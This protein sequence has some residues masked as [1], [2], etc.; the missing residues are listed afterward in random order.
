MMLGIWMDTNTDFLNIA[1]YNILTLS[2][3]DPK[4]EPYNDNKL[5]ILP[6]L[7]WKTEY[8]KFVL[9]IM[10]I[11]YDLRYRLY[12]YY[13]KENT[14][15]PIYLGLYTANFLTID[16]QIRII[17]RYVRKKLKIITMEKKM[18]YINSIDCFKR[19]PTL[20]ESVKHFDNCMKA[21]ND[22]NY[23]IVVDG[24]R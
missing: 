23:S 9:Y 1:F 11:D 14:F 24:L 12:L 3:R 2:I 5:R 6:K 8:K 4:F 19:K 16:E 20:L 17:K 7:Y 21:L 15:I 22:D 10:S 13:P 18:K